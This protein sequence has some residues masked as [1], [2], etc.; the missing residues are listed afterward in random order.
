MSAGAAIAGAAA[1]AAAG[2]DE[3]TGANAALNEL[4]NNRLRH[5]TE[6]IKLKGL[7]ARWKELGYASEE[8]ARTRLEIASCG[9]ILC[10]QQIPSDD[11]TYAQAKAVQDLGSSYLFE[12]DRQLLLSTNNTRG[13]RDFFYDKIVDA[14]SDAWTAYRG[15]TY[16]LGVAET[17]GGGLGLSASLTALPVCATL[18]GCALPLSGATISADIAYT[19]LKTIVYGQPQATMG[20][21]AL[22]A[23]TGLSLQTSELIYAGLALAPTAIEA[24]VA[25]RAANAYGTARQTA[26]ATYSAGETASPGSVVIAAPK[27]ESVVG[28]RS[29]VAR[30]SLTNQSTAVRD[31]L[32]SPRRRGTMR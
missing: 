4:Q 2:R 25:N 16:A 5:R 13:S 30:R 27:A 9:M 17:V 6:D 12:R 3:L 1:S 28:G 20:A 22:S 15:N 19:G 10:A 31:F 8:Q 21:Q 23:A 26:R 18:V 11:V 24:V 14:G 32:I 7:I 29:E